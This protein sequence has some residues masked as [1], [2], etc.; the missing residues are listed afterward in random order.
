MLKNGLLLISFDSNDS[1]CFVEEPDSATSDYLAQTL[2]KL[3]FEGMSPGHRL[4]ASAVRESGLHFSHVHVP[5]RTGESPY[6][7]WQTV[8]RQRTAERETARQLCQKVGGV[9]HW[10]G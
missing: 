9:C 7:V 10:D 3:T 2:F 1:T 8:G 4:F 5:E 6:A